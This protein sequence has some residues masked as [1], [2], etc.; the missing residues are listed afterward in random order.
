MHA[1][2]QQAKFAGPVNKLPSPPKRKL[3][4]MFNV[5]LGKK[6]KQ[7]TG[8][9]PMGIHVYLQKHIADMTMKTRY[10]YVANEPSH[11]STKT[12]CR[13]DNEKYKGKVCVCGPNWHP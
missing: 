3:R 6:R 7:D 4:E 10:W 2:I 9:S 12:H 13:H 5:R 11:V 1:V 8:M